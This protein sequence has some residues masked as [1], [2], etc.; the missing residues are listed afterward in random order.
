MNKKKHG[1]RIAKSIGC[2]QAIKWFA[3]LLTVVQFNYEE[4]NNGCKAFQMY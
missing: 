1:T 4:M 3:T 2:M